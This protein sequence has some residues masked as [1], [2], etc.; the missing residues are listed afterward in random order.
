MRSYH[1]WEGIDEN[2]SGHYDLVIRFHVIEWC[3]PGGPWGLWDPYCHYR[4]H[5]CRVKEGVEDVDLAIEGYW[6]KTWLTNDEE[7]Y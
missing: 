6:W 7:C 5:F 4:E 2:T 1:L 3:W